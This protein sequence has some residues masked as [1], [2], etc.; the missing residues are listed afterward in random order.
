MNYRGS[1]CGLVGALM[2][3]EMRAAKPSSGPRKS[4]RKAKAP[5]DAASGEAPAAPPPD[6]PPVSSDA[7]P[8][9]PVIAA[10][11]AYE[12]AFAR[13]QDATATLL[14]IHVRTPQ[15][16]ITPKIYAGFSRQTD[17]S[18][19]PIAVGSH[20][21]IEAVFDQMLAGFR[22]WDAR[23]E[24][25]FAPA[26][27]DMRLAA[28]KAL[29]EV[30]AGSDAYLKSTGFSDAVDRLAEAQS[31]RTLAAETVGSM[32]PTTPAGLAAY[33]GY[34]RRRLE[35][36]ARLSGEPLPHDEA[37]PL[38]T[39][40]TAALRLGGPVGASATVPPASPTPPSHDDGF[41]DGW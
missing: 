10:I 8:A 4:V 2:L 13:F 25:H 7:G 40:E 24:R 21:E 6:S 32:M 36:R 14:A 3:G 34:I 23:W 15:H 31:A 19:T 22:G 9:D 1:R 37:W 33:V 16:Y 27:E 28:H 41:D 38:M 20:E 39:L 18:T 35:Y 30:R 11:D 17:G 26:I 5:Q 12:E 29:R